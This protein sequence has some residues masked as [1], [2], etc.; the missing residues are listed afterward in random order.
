[1]LPGMGQGH[2]Q[3][4]SCAPEML[5]IRVSSVCHSLQSFCGHYAQI[6]GARLIPHSYGVV[7]VEL[8][9]I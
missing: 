7:R 9:S 4:Q 5:L 3:L 1:M 8:L 6:A 2:G